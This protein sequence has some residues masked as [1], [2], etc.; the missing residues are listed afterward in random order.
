MILALSSSS[1]AGVITAIATTIFAV[2]SFVTAFTLLV[3]ILRVT[4][5]THVIVNQEKT[6]RQ[7]YQRALIAALHNAG[8]AIPVDQSVPL[9]VEAEPTGDK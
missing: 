4:K 9:S 8:V 2:S 5:S 6:D 7:R 1:A 3:P